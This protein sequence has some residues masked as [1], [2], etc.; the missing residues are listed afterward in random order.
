VVTAYAAGGS[1]RAVISVDQ[2]MALSSFKATLGQLEPM[3][4]G[5][6]QEFQQAIA[7]IFEQMAG[8]LDGAERWRVDHIRDADQEVVV[9]IWDVVF[10]TSVDELDAVVDAV[11]DAI[12]VPYLSL[13]GIDPGPDHP[14]WLTSRV[15]SATVEV[16]PALGH[17]PHLIDPDRFVQRVVDFDTRV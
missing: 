13:H 8:R 2:P 5:T 6:E 12:T 3:L 4:K 9:G 17:Y 15:P 14:A 10:S 1:C 16:W 7:A 11:L